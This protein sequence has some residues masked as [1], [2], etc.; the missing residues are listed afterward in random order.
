M[1]DL[2]SNMTS[3]D[4]A[5]LA[6]LADNMKPVLGQ[7]AQDMA[8]VIAQEYNKLEPE[9]AHVLA[10]AAGKLSTETRNSLVNALVDMK[11]GKGSDKFQAL[12]DANPSLMPPEIVASVKKFGEDQIMKL[13]Q[14]VLADMP[15][16]LQLAVA[17]QA[18]A[19]YTGFDRTDNPL[20]RLATLVTGGTTPAE[21]PADS[22][23]PPPATA[24][25]AKSWWDSFTGGDN[26]SDDSPLGSGI[27]GKFISGIVEV[28]A[29]I[30][31]LF[32][33]IGPFVK[34]LFNPT[35]EEAE[36]PF[37][38]RLAD[39][40]Q[41]AVEN[42][43]ENFENVRDNLTGLT[44]NEKSYAAYLEEKHLSVQTSAAIVASINGESS[45][46][47]HGGLGDG[48]TS[49]GLCQ[50][51]N[52]RLTEM[53]AATGHTD[54]YQVSAKEQLDYIA[55][56]LTKGP[57]KNIGDAM[58]AAGSVEEANRIFVAQYERPKALNEAI[59]S[60]GET[61]ERIFHVMQNYSAEQIEEAAAP[62]GTPSSVAPNNGNTRSMS[63]I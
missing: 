59:A 50:W 60:R 63:A 53:L 16:E 26:S 57:H 22:D 13:G 20:N 45:C 58:E 3:E 35:G 47:P 42:G 41:H 30:A 31:A 6:A 55:W 1:A 11:T 14:D 9:L 18:A 32:M 46:N 48:G 8:P 39:A 56:D 15:H 27:I 23:T 4:K 5:K 40:G 36:K 28:V 44:N 2:A 34:E 21:T 33:G 25:P 7:V 61:A 38:Q 10:D 29:M 49:G 17:A 19:H 37:F 62:L 24:T 51:H 12:L 54:I 43:R 52:E